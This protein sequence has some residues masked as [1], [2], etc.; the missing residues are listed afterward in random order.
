MSMKAILGRKI[1][2]TEVFA[3]DGTMYPVT[4][5]EVLPNVVTQVKTVEKDGY[6]AVQVGYEDKKESRA[7]K[8]EKG[9]AKKANTV[10][11][12]IS[13]ELRG[14]EMGKYQLGDKI[15]CDLFAKG[16]IV[17]VIGTSKGKGYTGTIK[18]W[19]MI[20]GPKGHG[21]GYH[22][23]Q[24]SFA[25]Q[26]RY[27][28]GVMPGKHMSGHHGNKSVTLLNVQLVDVNAEKGYVLVKGGIPG[29]TKGIVTIRSHIKTVKNA[30]SVKPLIVLNETAKEE[31]PAPAAAEA[32]AE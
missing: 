8:A 21:S 9:I 32:K 14:D 15:T 28:H 31:A 22:R 23:G 1:G 3:E 19:N 6:V 29:P 2:M 11:H 12:Y 7:N 17:D 26:G 20:I 16:D 27:N 24:G 13:K 30:K 25:N 4:V 10:P 18:R 5:V